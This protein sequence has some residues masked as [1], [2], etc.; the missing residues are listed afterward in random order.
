MSGHPTEEDCSVHLKLHF[1]LSLESGSR[2][3][4]WCLNGRV[5][6][7]QTHLQCICSA[8]SGSP[9][10]K[11]DSCRLPASE[12]RM[13]AGTTVTNLSRICRE[14]SSNNDPSL[15][16]ATQIEPRDP[17]KTRPKAMALVFQSDSVSD[18]AGLCSSRQESLGVGASSLLPYGTWC[19]M[20][21]YTQ[22]A[23]KAGLD[24]DFVK[25]VSLKARERRILL[26][27]LGIDPG[28]VVVKD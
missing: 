20:D 24:A 23:P 26:D 14:A 27:M 16:L 3:E 8:D 12:H 9:D 18:S 25:V 19:L 6:P 22:Q 17:P 15:D 10:S 21:F 2:F 7:L 11:P 13:S 4:N 28:A 1:G 5:A